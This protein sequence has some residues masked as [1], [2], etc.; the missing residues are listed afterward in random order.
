MST[1]P[2][3]QAAGLNVKDATAT[4]VAALILFL[5]IICLSVTP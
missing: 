2:S 4:I 1:S 3:D 5:L